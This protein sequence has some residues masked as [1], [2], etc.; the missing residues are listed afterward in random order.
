MLGRQDI[1]DVLDRSY[2]R[3]SKLVKLSDEWISVD[4]P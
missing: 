2:S 4:I 1:R 3:L